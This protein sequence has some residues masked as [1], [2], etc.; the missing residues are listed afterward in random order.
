MFPSPVFLS[1]TKMY[2]TQ[3]C[4]RSISEPPKNSSPLPALETESNYLCIIYY[5][6]I[7]GV[8]RSYLFPAFERGE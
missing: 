1:K 5:T 2:N 6:I 4:A 8:L 7:C 3:S